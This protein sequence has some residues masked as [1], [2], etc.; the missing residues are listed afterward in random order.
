[1]CVC[2]SQCVCLDLS[3][4][5]SSFQLDKKDCV[6]TAKIENLKEAEPA[7]LACNT[8]PE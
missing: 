6:L 3:V 5:V 4:C 8:G 7:Y 1:V 2:L